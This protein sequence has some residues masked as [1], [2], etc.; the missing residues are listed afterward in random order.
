MPPPKESPNILRAP[1]D[2]EVTPT[3]HSDTYPSISP[4]KV[5]LT[6]L[7]VLITGGSR[8]LGHAMAL[9]FAAAGASYIA[10]CARTSLS[11]LSASIKDAAIAAKRAEPQFLGLETDVTD[12]ESVE[13]AVKAVESAFGGRLDVVVN[14]AGVLG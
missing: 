9:S 5:N 12:P 4:Q 7:A 13:R 8:G 1:G 6:G 10:V 2:Y 11:S 3:I 14:N